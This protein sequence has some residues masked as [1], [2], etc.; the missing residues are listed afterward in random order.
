MIYCTVRPVAMLVSAVLCLAPFGA[1]PVRARPR[2]DGPAIVVGFHV[3]PPG[4]GDVLELPM[5][6]AELRPRAPNLGLFDVWLVVFTRAPLVGAWTLNVGLGYDGCPERGVD[7]LDWEA[8]S[9]TVRPRP[10]WPAAGA[11]FGAE[12]IWD[13]QRC[14]DVDHRLMRGRNGWWVQVACRLRVRV[15][16]ADS[17][18]LADPEPDV[19]PAEVECYDEG[20]DL[21]GTD[22]WTA[23]VPAVFDADGGPGAG[24]DADVP[25]S[26]P[27]SG[28]TLPAPTPVRALTWSQLKRGTGGR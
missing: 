17:L 20:H 24:S 10:A 6:P 26:R 22:N 16:S 25:A 1:G 18:T 21:D 28:C 23:I 11:G 13:R 19:R 15:H 27:G 12:F 5:A 14:W 9:D 7:V 8:L 3:A 2:L 4:P